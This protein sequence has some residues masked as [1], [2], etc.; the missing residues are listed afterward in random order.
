MA[1]EVDATFKEVSSETSLTDSVRLVS[2]SFSTTA[3][4][5]II[6]ICCMSKALA[7]AMQQRADA[8]ATATAQE[9]NGPQAP[10][11]MSNPAFQIET[12]P[13]PILCM[14]DIPL[15]STLQVGCL[16]IRFI[17]NP[18]HK[19][20]DHSPSSA[21]D[22]QSGKRAHAKTAEA[23]VSIGHNTPQGKKEPPR[24]PLETPNNDTVA[25]GST[26]EH[27][28]GDNTNHCGDQSTQDVSRENMANSI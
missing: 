9:L 12:P 7:T 24:I 2:C 26:E 10:A 18:P 25:S 15:I 4:P 16:L 17:F 23:N 5:G 22:D 1:K 6:P 27:D 20:Q 3:N 11:S 21:P 8:P 19:M 14:S 28:S 13:L